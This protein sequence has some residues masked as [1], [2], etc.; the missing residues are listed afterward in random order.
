MPD[1]PLSP[2][3]IGD[4]YI[5]S[6]ASTARIIDSV[7]ESQ[8][9]NSTPCSEW[10]VKDVV[11]HLV[12]ENRWMVALFEGQTIAEVG[13]RFDGD[14]VGDDPKNVYRESAAEVL[15]I[16]R[17]DDAMSR[18]CQIS[19]G[20]V[21]GAEYASQ[22]FLDTLVHGWDISVGAEAPAALDPELV[23]ACI[24]LA[25]T[26]AAYAAG[27]GSFAE[28]VPVNSDTDPQTRL[29]AILGRAS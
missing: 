18:T 14:L 2:G 12:Y 9:S 21:T 22:L 11:N 24:P 27:S 10:D 28:S 20:P 17:Q 23:D 26:T 7:D 16:L 4:C 19:S 15:A 29:L 5:R 6:I 13:D 25:E 1:L 3:K 8:W